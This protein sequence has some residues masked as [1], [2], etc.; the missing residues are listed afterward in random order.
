MILQFNQSWSESIYIEVISRA[1]LLLLL[2]VW[3]AYLRKNL[4]A[5]VTI[6]NIIP[7]MS[8]SPSENYFSF[9]PEQLTKRWW[10][11][12]PTLHQSKA[13]KPGSDA[14][15]VQYW[16]SQWQDLCISIKDLS[17]A[18]QALSKVSTIGPALKSSVMGNELEW[19]CC[20]IIF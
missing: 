7:D 19:V 1:V 8:V 20:E 17:I 13:A 5:D 10:H 18:W 14:V 6:N 12:T 2:L 16:S 3:R 15:H 9:Y 11:I 4:G